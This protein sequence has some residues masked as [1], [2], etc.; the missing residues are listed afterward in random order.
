MSERRRTKGRRTLL[1]RIALAAA[2]NV[3]RVRRPG[4]RGDCRLRRR[5]IRVRLL[6]ALRVPLGPKLAVESILTCEA[7]S[8]RSQ[9][10]GKQASKETSER[11]RRR[12][13]S[14]ST[15]K[16]SG[17]GK[18][19]THIQSDP[20]IL[21]RRSDPSRRPSRRTRLLRRSARRRGTS[22]SRRRRRQAQGRR[23]RGRAE[24]LS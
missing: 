14:G 12:G 5:R 7:A 13:R 15:S 18:A 4:R 17:E 21:F 9:L 19:T 1:P 8:E 16:P 3:C 11:A 22:R 23:R 24:E 10:E 20:C 2:G 6:N